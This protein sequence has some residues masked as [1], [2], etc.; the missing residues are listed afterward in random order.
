[1]N[2]IKTIDNY[3]EE[4]LNFISM[5]LLDESNPKND[6]YLG[7]MKVVLEFKTLRLDT[8]NADI[9]KGLFKSWAS[10]EFEAYKNFH[11]TLSGIDIENYEASRRYD[12][13][14]GKLDECLLFFERFNIRHQYISD[15]YLKTSPKH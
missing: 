15:Y 9:F 4:R 2:M 1:M 6:Y 12:S 8:A 11:E 7:A 10:K 5:R 3:M 14:I 13:I